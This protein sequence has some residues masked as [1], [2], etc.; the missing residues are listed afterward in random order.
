MYQAENW[1]YAELLRKIRYPYTVI[2]DRVIATVDNQTIHLGNATD[3][4]RMTPAQIA[5]KITAYWR[6]MERESNKKME[7]QA[8]KDG[9]KFGDFLLFMNPEFA[10]YRGWWDIGMMFAKIMGHSSL[11]NGVAFVTAMND[12]LSLYKESNARQI[13]QTREL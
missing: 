5:D 8:I 11:E 4:A 10:N 3:V 2:E 1:V 6:S 12:R 9:A 13:A 7:E